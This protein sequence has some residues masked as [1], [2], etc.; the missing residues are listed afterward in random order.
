MTTREAGDVLQVALQHSE[1]SSMLLLTRKI[2]DVTSNKYGS[3]KSGLYSLPH[4]AF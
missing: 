1:A 4:W 2:S 3:D